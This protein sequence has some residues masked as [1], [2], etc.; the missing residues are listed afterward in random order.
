MRALKIALVG[1]VVLLLSGRGYNKLQQQDE[2]V[3]S[4]WSEV[5]N[6]YQRR[7]DL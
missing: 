2:A 6:Q 7:A 1:A 3:G 5:L 4:A